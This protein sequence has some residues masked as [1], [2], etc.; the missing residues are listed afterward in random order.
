MIAF[1]EILA[2]AAGAPEPDRVVRY[3]PHPAQTAGLWRAGGGH[4]VAPEQ[5]AAAA[6][7]PVLIFLHGGCWLAEYGVGHAA[8]AADALRRLGWAVW[9]PEYRR[10]GDAGGGDPGTFDD[11][12]RGIHALADLLDEEGLDPAAVVLMGHSAGGHLALWVAGESVFEA[13]GMA[14]RGVVSLAGIASLVAYR[15]PEGCGASVDLL[16]GGSPERVPDAFRRRDPVQRPSLGP[17]IPVVLVEADADMIVPRSQGEVYRAHDPTATV[18]RVAGGHFDLIA[19]WAPA[20]S[21]VVGA[22]RELL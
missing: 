6:R 9:T 1:D 10:V 21:G 11:V 4:G 17:R 7:T 16:L 5:G 14:L 2:A 12:V 18:W 22:V 15:S 3:G 8:P 20:W 13:R 19:P